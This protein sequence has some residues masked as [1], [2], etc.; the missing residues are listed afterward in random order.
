MNTKDQ[1][2][3]KILSPE[4][5]E[6]LKKLRG[7]SPKSIFLWTPDIYKENLPKEE[8]PIFKFSNRDAKDLADAEDNFLINLVDESNAKSNSSNLRL[9]I[10]KK[11]I[12]G[13]KNYFDKQNKPIEYIEKDGEITNECL[14]RLSSE[15]QEQILD[16]INAESHLTDEEKEGLEF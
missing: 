1:T 7:F 15:I 8:W 13:W 2:V 14:Y 9:I 3:N 4:I 5:E 10:L 16:A 11:N 6:K 12:K